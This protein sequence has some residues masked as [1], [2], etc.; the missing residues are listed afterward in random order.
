MRGRA[1]ALSCP[2][3]RP[4]SDCGTVTI[5]SPHAQQ[6]AAGV[7]GYSHL[8]P[9]A[10]GTGG[11]G[12]GA[13]AELS[14][15]GTDRGGRWF[16]RCDRRL[17]GAPARGARAAPAA[18]RDAGA[19]SQRRCPP[20]ARRVPG[21]PG[22]RRPVAAAQ[23]GAAGGG[24]DGGRR[25]DLARA[26]ALGAL[27]PGALATLAAA[28]AQRRPVRGLAAQVRDRAVDRAVAARR[29]R[30]GR[31]L[32]RRPGDRRGL[33]VVAAP[34]GALPGGLPGAGTGDQARRP[35]GSAFGAV[36]TDRDIPPA[37]AARPGRGGSLRRRVPALRSL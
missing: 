32:S 24:G 11:G 19:G 16:H 28:P 36:W 13:G 22:L 3:R 23:A 34:D 9:R 14:A 18:Y 26:G 1:P 7:G 30:A 6:Y 4:G 27:R 25:R 37:G 35:F 15:A 5:A 31:R 21:I 8:Q 12:L 17:S 20:G 29:V 2:G 10:A 33:R